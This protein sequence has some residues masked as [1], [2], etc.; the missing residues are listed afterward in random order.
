M[1]KSDLERRSEPNPSDRSRI[2]S[3]RSQT[4]AIQGIVDRGN[5]NTDA[6]LGQQII[7]TIAILTVWLDALDSRRDEIEVNK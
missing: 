6:F 7:K 1:E 3:L 2:L 4:G 5:E